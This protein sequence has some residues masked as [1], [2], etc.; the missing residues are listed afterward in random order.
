MNS[1]ISV[2]K[3][4]I[5]FIILFII[6]NLAFLSIWFKFGV[7]SSINHGY[8]ELQKEVSS[9]IIDNIQ[10]SIQIN[11]KLEIDEL[12]QKIADK[13]SLIII[14]RDENH[15]IVFNNAVNVSDREY[16]TPFMININDENY[17]ISV[18]K[19][20]EINTIYI[21]KR[22]MVFE[23]IFICSITL[24]IILIANKLLVDPIDKT[25]EDINNY[26][27]GIKPKKRKATNEIYYLQNEFVDLTKSLEKEHEEQNRIISAISHDIRTPLTSI[28]GYSDLLVNKNLKKSEMKELQ[29]KIYKKALD[30]KDITLDF[31]DYL[32][33]NSNRTYNYKEVNIKDL[34]N[35]LKLE[36]MDD[37][38]DKSIKF[39][40][41]NK[42]R[43]SSLTI[44]VGKVHRIFSNLITN[45]IRHIDKNGIIKL[46]IKDDKEFFYFIFSD[47]GIGVPEENLNKIFEPL[48][49]TDRSRKISGLGLSISKEIVEMHGG[50]IKAYNNKDKGLT[51]EFTI[52]KKIEIND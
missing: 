16:L 29:E 11:K 20:N 49:T 21:T 9:E 30:M 8:E 19:T 43:Q 42:T 33:S 22:F 24:L 36:Y 1:K 51:I 44:D 47:N 23:I 12:F 28:I 27:F 52:S 5:S 3:L 13:Y 40:I 7:T 4:L 39:N 50:T 45:S 41:I 31:E 46:E 48:F 26:K 17:L 37:L 32:T 25:I 15:N 18:G 6:V 10:K 35:N 34:I 38:K 2:Q 14:V